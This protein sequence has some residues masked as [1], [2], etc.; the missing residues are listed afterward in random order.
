VTLI[1]AASIEI[2]S[3][4]LHLRDELILLVS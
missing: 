1:G 2:L 4:L 3:M